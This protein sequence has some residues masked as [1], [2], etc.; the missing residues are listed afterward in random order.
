[1]TTIRAGTG[2]KIQ[3]VTSEVRGVGESIKKSFWQNVEEAVR[4]SRF[5][6]ACVGRTITVEFQFSLGEQIGTERGSFAYANRFMIFAPAKVVQGF[7][8]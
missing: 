8:Q 7:N 6:A 3:D 4:A 5:A 2:G 1:M